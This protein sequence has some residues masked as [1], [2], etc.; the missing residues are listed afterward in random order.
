MK[1]YLQNTI[2]ILWLLT[3]SVGIATSCTPDTPKVAPGPE[4]TVSSAAL[5]VGDVFDVRVF[6]EKELS[7]TYRVGS[8]GS[9]AFPLVGR[10]QVEGKIALEVSVLLQKEL[11]RFVRNPSVSVFVKEFNSKKIYVLGQ[12]KRPGTLPYQD[13]MNIIQ[14]VTTA[15]GFG[16]LAD[17]NGTY[18]TRRIDGKETRI[19]VAVKDIG[20]GEAPNFRLQP[21]DIIYVPE[22]IF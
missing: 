10:L 12:V 5:G 20:R 14:A 17:Q 3:I 13:G 15:G 6:G 2:R 11:Q 21:G 7:G 9:I 1:R 19:K 16:A 8:D 18:V 4:T 22:T